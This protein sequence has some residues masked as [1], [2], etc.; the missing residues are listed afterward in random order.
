[1]KPL[2]GIVVALIAWIAAGVCEESLPAAEAAPSIGAPR[3][4]EA[5]VL[6]LS[7]NITE[8]VV[9]LGARDRL[10]GVSDFCRAHLSVGELPRCGA[11]VNPNFE[12]IL[13]LHPDLLFYLGR[14]EKLQRFCADRGIR[15][16][17]IHIDGWAALR[18][19]TARIGK[20]LGAEKAAGVLIAG[21]DRRLAAVRAAARGAA[22]P[23]CLILLGRET[24]GLRRMMSVGGASFLSEML[25]AAGGD[26][27]FVDQPQPYFTPSREAILVA[28]PDVI[29]ELR[30]GEN[31]SV[32]ERAAVLDD[33]KRE[34]SVPA[35]AHGKI[36]VFTEDFLMTPGPRMVEI[37]E[38]FQSTLHHFR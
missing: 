25:D 7:P 21:L 26:N 29:L 28:R 31:L 17:S 4:S 9:A 24:G 1:M 10:V 11:A 14:M 12:R 38:L 30:P 19:E 18:A 32:T 27:V 2:R 37:A 13:A 20:E 34:A 15:A 33:W 16:L 3:E 35:V 8:I 23:R 22:R 6:S 5:R 36:A